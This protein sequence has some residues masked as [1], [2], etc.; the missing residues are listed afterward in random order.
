M[1]DGQKYEDWLKN[2]GRVEDGKGSV[3]IHAPG[4]AG[5]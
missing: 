2:K 1:P 5:A 4:I 3:G